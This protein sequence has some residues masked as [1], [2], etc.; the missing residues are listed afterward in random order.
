MIE[1]PIIKEKDHDSYTDFMTSNAIRHR[2][3]KHIN[4]L[5]E[6]ERSAQREKLEVLYKMGISWKGIQV[7]MIGSHHGSKN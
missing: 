7:A 5:P 3:M 6:E 1:G 2:V 4:N